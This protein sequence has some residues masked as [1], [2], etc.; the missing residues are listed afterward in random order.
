MSSLSL[1]KVALRSKP[2][3]RNHLYFIA[4]RRISIASDAMHLRR[5]MSISSY[6]RSSAPI[7]DWGLMSQSRRNNDANGSNF[8]RKENGQEVQLRYFS[9]QNSTFTSRRTERNKK[10]VTLG[11]EQKWR[12]ILSLW[13]NESEE[14]SDINYANTMSRLKTMPS[15]DKGDPTF[16][17]FVDELATLIEDRG[18]HWIGPR[19]LANIAHSLG[20]MELRK[21]QGS[22]RIMD[23]ISRNANRIVQEAD[24]QNLSNIAWAFGKLGGRGGVSSSSTNLF[25]EAFEERSTWFVENGNPQAVANTAWS[26]AKR[27][28]RSPKFFAQI[29]EDPARMVEKG[30]QQ[31]VANTAWACAKLGHPMPRM[32]AQIEKHS[33][34]LIAKGDNPQ[35]LANLAWACAKLR[36]K[37]PKLFEEI[38]ERAAWLVESGSPQS[39]A[40]TASA[41]A[42]LGVPAP[43]LFDAI[44]KRASWLAEKGNIIELKAIA[45]ACST[46]GVKSPFQN[47]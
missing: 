13:E 45:G 36:R 33:N 9:Q 27:G 18:L 1:L 44:Q 35:Q 29:E 20:K 39:I 37:S 26:C 12:E 15:L 23:F 5:P 3:H 38:E 32:F 47:L 8:W 6:G 22:K 34:W 11:K 46:L 2:M 21:M 25:F 4:P 10:I 40:N 14:Y 7:A 43:K 28:I 31:N 24:P 16:V 17:R 19:Q 42:T 41:F 30:N